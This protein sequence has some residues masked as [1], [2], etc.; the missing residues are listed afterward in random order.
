MYQ[1]FVNHEQIENNKI[2][3]IGSDVNH[4]KNVLRLAP[5]E[6]IQIVDKSNT[7]KFLC[8]LQEIT[9]EVVSCEIIENIEET[10]E[11][12]VYLHIFQGLPKADKL[13]WIIEKSTEI[14]VK[15]ITPMIMQRSIVKLGEKDKD[16]KLARWRKIAETI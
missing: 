1:F 7:Q 10:N 8:K 5:E 2:M 11:V 15:E 9:K 13:E 16:K 12:G 14:G 4:I 6:T 3:I